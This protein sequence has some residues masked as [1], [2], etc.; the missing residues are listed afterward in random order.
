MI[1]NAERETNA[2][3]STLSSGMQSTLVDG[4]QP[5][6]FTSPPKTPFDSCV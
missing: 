2:T 5:M 4:A 6:S 3:G 1:N